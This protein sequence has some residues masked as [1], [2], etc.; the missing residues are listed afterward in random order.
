MYWASVLLNSP[1]KFLIASTRCCK[2]SGDALLSDSNTDVSQG[3]LFDDSYQLSKLIGQNH[4][5][6]C[7]G[8][9]KRHCKRKGQAIGLPLKHM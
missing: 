4:N 7:N 3:G 5:A 9:S 8:K 6:T 1:K 2:R